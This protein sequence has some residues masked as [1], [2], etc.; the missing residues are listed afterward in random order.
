MR[1]NSIR[2]AVV[3]LVASCFFCSCQLKT[4][5]QPTE[6]GETY[7][8]MT[9]NVRN[10]L[11]MDEIRNIDRVAEV[12]N[13]QQPDVLALQ[14]LDSVTRRC[15]NRYMLG[16]LAEK[17]QMH[18]VFAPAIDFNGGKYGVGMLSKEKPLGYVSYP[19][20]GR[21]EKR[22]LLVVE[23][24]NFVFCC[25]HLSLT[26]EDQLLSLPIINKVTAAYAKPVLI[27]GDM[28][29]HPDHPFI[30]ELQHSFK[31]VSPTDIETFPADTPVETLD[32]IAIHHKDTARV[33]AETSLVVKAPLASDH[34]PVVATITISTT[35]S[36][37]DTNMNKSADT[38]T[39]NAG[40]DTK[41]AGADTD[42]AGA[43][44]VSSTK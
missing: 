20:P 12:I 14:E 11:G 8:F 17:T 5:H 25:T 31:V 1:K 37:S 10:G 29:A 16:E 30:K 26:P 21:E 24:K 40:T 43:D 7:Q 39:E 27:A 28:N 3:S 9:Y 4:Q 13:Q 35:D 22:T 6:T 19:L 18:P 33:K 32:Y 41:S 38:A 23:F 15:D 34:R 44:M 36:C 42:N 2:T